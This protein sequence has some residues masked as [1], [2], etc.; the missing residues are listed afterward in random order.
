M[1]RES[2]CVCVC[3]RVTHNMW[4]SLRVGEEGGGPTFKCWCIGLEINGAFTSVT[5]TLSCMSA[6]VRLLA[7]HT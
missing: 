2:V 4:Q 1:V 6:A 7:V 5:C 3:E